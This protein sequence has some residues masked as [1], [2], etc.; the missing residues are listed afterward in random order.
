MFNKR[1]YAVTNEWTSQSVNRLRSQPVCCIKK[2]HRIDDVMRVAIIRYWCRCRERSA[3][4]SRRKNLTRVVRLVIVVVVDRGNSRLLALFF[5]ST[6]KK[7]KIP[8]QLYGGYGL[9]SVAI[10]SRVSLYYTM[11]VTSAHAVINYDGSRNHYRGVSCNS[12]VLSV[13]I[14]L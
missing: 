5:L 10:I 13:Y 2:E 7:K 1:H 4:S 6:R 14:R 11:A 9:I 8:T 12:G 3:N